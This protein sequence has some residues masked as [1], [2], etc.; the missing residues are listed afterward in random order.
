MAPEQ[1]EGQPAGPAADMWALGGTLY[2]MV[3]G[4]PP[5]EG[6]TLTSVVTAI[7]ASDPAP[8]A[9]AGPLLGLIG[10]LLV[11]D[12]AVRPAAAEVVRQLDVLRHSGVGD[13]AAQLPA[14]PDG[15][16]RDTI[17]IKTPTVFSDGGGAT[18]P[19]GPVGP[20]GPGGAMGSGSSMGPGGQRS[21][22]GTAAAA[23]FLRTRRGQLLAGVTAAV[24]VAVVVGVVLALAPSGATG[25]PAALNSSPTAHGS[26]SP[27]AS[28][29]LRASTSATPTK[30]KPTP[31]PPPVG[32]AC[33]IGTWRANGVHQTAKYDGV[34]V[35]MYGSEGNVDHIAAS[36]VDTDVYGPDTFPEY[37]TYNGS[38]LEVDLQGEAKEIIHAYPAKHNASVLADGWTVGSTAK[39]VYQGS[40]TQGY[41]DKPSTKPITE[42]YRCTA[43]TLVWTEKGKTVETETRVSTKP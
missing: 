25:N 11:K 27:F 34:T 21:P 43:T 37:G 12:P 15:A 41:F 42:G 33:L 8:P 36:G 30:P 26:G 6:P 31:K 40:T 10:L 23:A 4:R 17:T 38:S 14:Q 1:L 35:Q 20:G 2:A 16:R 28:A 22:A 18:G 39:Y 7:L 24:A 9:H 13:P 19:G 5:F 29:A 32:D 3:E